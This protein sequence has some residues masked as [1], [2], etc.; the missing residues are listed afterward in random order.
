[1][2]FVCDEHEIAHIG[3]PDWGPVYVNRLAYTRPVHAVHALPEAPGS[4]SGT[5]L[6]D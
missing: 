6:D 4:G 5:A 2:L 3:L 1:M